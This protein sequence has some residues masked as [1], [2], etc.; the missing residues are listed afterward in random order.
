MFGPDVIDCPAM[1]TWSIF[2]GVLMLDVDAPRPAVAD[3]GLVAK[4]QFAR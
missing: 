3:L 2:V 4:V 1:L